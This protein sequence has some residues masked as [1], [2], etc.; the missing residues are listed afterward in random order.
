MRT[1]FSSALPQPQRGPAVSLPLVTDAVPV[2]TGPVNPD[3]TAGAS[4]P[5]MSFKTNP[6]L[7]SDTQYTLVLDNS[8]GDSQNSIT[9]HYDPYAASSSTGA[10][11]KVVPNNL[12]INLDAVDAVSINALRLAF[13]CQGGSKSWAGLADA[14]SRHSGPRLDHYF[15]CRDADA[16]IS[17]WFYY[18]S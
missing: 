4:V 12:Y 15:G 10:D 9:A 6:A 14:I 13:A 2:V 5:G 17:R 1:I 8:T 11:G 7:R 18:P 16:G 3:I